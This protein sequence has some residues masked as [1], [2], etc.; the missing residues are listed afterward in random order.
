MSAVLYALPV[1]ALLGV[2]A[3]LRWRALRRREREA[4]AWA[5]TC[6][7]YPWRVAAAREHPMLLVYPD[8]VL[9][10][11]WEREGRRYPSTGGRC[12]RFDRRPLREQRRSR[13]MLA[14]A[15]GLAMGGGWC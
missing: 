1:V 6:A 5:D 9:R 3:G 14:C 11:W 15:L 10:L 8:D 2:L 12:R 7:R 13:A 4:R